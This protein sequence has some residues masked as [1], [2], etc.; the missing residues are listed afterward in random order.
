MANSTEDQGTAKK[1]KPKRGRAVAADIKKGKAELQD[2]ELNK[3]TGG[4]PP[5][6]PFNY[7]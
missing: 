2:D 4:T 1:P 3:V 5:S 6:K 7:S